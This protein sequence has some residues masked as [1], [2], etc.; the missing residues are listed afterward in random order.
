M[1]AATANTSF[2]C[3]W[4]G[5]AAAALPASSRQQF[6]TP[7]LH[8]WWEQYCSFHPLPGQDKNN[9]AGGPPWPVQPA[10]LPWFLP[11]DEGKGQRCSYRLAGNPVFRNTKQTMTPSTGR[12]PAFFPEPNA[13]RS[14]N[15]LNSARESMK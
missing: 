8:P 2:R 4:T 7:V 5:D 15:D 6:A 13:L 1:T 11:E 9:R 14:R 12:R 10:I 3:G